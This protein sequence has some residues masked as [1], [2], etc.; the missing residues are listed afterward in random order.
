MPA[1]ALAFL[2][3]LGYDPR[4]PNEI[5]SIVEMLETERSSLYHVWHRFCGD[6]TVSLESIIAFIKDTNALS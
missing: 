3:Y 2:C 4:K 1:E 5:L 6:T